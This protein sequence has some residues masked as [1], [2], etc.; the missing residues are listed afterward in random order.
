MVKTLPA[1]AGDT[2]SIPDM[3]DPTW[4]GA[5]EPIRHNYWAWALEP[6]ELQLLRQHAKAWALELELHNKK[7]H[8]SEKPEHC[9]RQ[10]ILLAIKE[11]KKKKGHAAKTQHSQK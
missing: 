7:S 4:H 11:K 2:G 1:N 9:N 6:Q 3:E 10:Q 8:H 5:T